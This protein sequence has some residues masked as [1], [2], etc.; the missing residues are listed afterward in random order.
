MVG[1]GCP[2]NRVSLMAKRFTDTNKWGKAKFMA[3]P[4][5]IKLAWIYLLDNCN[6]AGIWDINLVLMNVQ[7]GEN[8]SLDELMEHFGDRIKMFRDGKIFIPSFIEFQYGKL[9]DANRAHNSVISILKKEGLYKP[10]ISPFQGAKDKDKDK[11]K[12]MDKEKARSSSEFC[13]LHY[14]P[15]FQCVKN[16]LSQNKIVSPKIK[17]HMPEIVEQFETAE[18]FE[19]WFENLRQQK[20]YRSLITHAEKTNYFT[21]ALLG[22]IGALNV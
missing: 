12:E 20:K 7:I 3:W 22:E 5:K 2:E 6:H 9:S 19:T 17:R 13:E 21:A 15:V 8:I 16:V 11:D 18:N 4:A 1:S 14:N 10:F